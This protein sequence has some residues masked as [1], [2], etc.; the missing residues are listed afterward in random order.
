M[1]DTHRARR[2]VRRSQRLRAGLARE[3]FGPDTRIAKPTVEEYREV[4]SGDHH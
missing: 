1:T 2:P 3:M 4:T